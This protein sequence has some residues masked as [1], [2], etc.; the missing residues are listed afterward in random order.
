MATRR[1]T[2]KKNSEESEKEM[3][4]TK[5]TTTVV[6]HTGTPSFKIN[7]KFKNKKQKEMHDT[8]LAN[9][10]TFVR[11]AAGTGKAQP[12]YC[13]ILTPDGWKLMGDVKIGDAIITP[14]NKISHINGV[15]PQ[16][17]KDIYKIIFSDNTYTFSCDEHLWA[18]KDEKLRNKRFRKNNISYKT[19]TDFKILS[20]NDIIPDINNRG[21]LNFNIPMVNEIEF[22][23]KNTKMSPY[24]MGLLL[25]DGSFRNSISFTSNDIE[26]QNYIES[27]VMSLNCKL[28][29]FRQK[30]DTK[31]FNITGYKQVNNILEIIKEYGLYNTTSYTKFIPSDYINSNIQDRKDILAGLLDTDGYI[32]K[33]NGVTYFYTVSEKLKDNVVEIVNSLGGTVKVTSRI[34]KYK[35]K[36]EMKQGK[37]C[38]N[39]CLSLNFN[40]F[41]LK[42]K[43]DLYQVKTKYT[44]VRYIK[45]VEYIGK[46]EAQCISVEDSKHL[47]I[48]DNYI[49]THN[50][51]VSLLTALEC[52]KDNS[53]NIDQIVLTK[54]IVE[55][56]SSK[57][58]GALPGGL[59]EKTLSYYTHFYDTL[60]KLIGNDST[61]LLKERGII[62][63]TILNFLRGSTFGKWDENGKPVGSFCIF[64]EAQNCTPVEMKTFISRMGEESKLVIMGDSDQI[65]L[66]LNRGDKCGLDDAW[67]RLQGVPGIGY[68]EFTEDDI[69]RDPFLIEIMKRYKQ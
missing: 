30:N 47:Y 58:L 37:K 8:I 67:D 27:E 69:V 53:V 35:Y 18:V 65:D 55:I 20:L 17:I 15:F 14:E 28:S 23:K 25:G 59:D 60:I 66:K 48:T 16:G 9:R 42:R 39:L 63:D 11:G 54:P 3:L 44:P 46:E 29:N 64:D 22:G 32:D 12:L 40:P 7:C 57:G 4:P 38:Y 2:T 45:H 6:K 31:Y 26:I 52:I 19:E 34:G 49:V 5:K 10:I 33:R 61:K 50:T 13:K 24:L 68:V 21:R 36:G 51:F 41:K 62:K 1:R 43:F 56:T